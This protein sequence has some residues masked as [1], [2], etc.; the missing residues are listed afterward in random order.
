MND[1]PRYTGVGAH[2]GTPVRVL[3]DMVVIAIALEDLGYVCRTGDAPECDKAFRTGVR[4]GENIEV[5]ERGSGT[6]ESIS[7]ALKLHPNHDAA[8]KDIRWLGR[9]PMQVAGKDLDKPSKFTV[10][11]TPGGEVVGGT[12]LTIRVSRY[13]KVPVLNLHEWTKED[14]IDVARKVRENPRYE[15]RLECRGE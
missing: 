7:L 13:F 4:H 10:C 12:G 11:W 14:V 6:P 1:K 15:I 5:Y 9:N 3:R 8:K 2:E